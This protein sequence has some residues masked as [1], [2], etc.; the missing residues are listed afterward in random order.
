MSGEYYDSGAAYPDPLAVQLAD[1]NF[2]SSGGGSSVTV[3]S[4]GGDANFD[5]GA[6]LATTVE[7]PLT[8][9][10]ATQTPAIQAVQTNIQNFQDILPADLTS[11]IQSMSQQERL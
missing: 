10:F 5:T 6:N 4:I 1:P 8:Q 3:Q 7:A 11:Q 2:F 9:E